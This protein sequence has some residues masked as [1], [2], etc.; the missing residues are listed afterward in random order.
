MQPV[1]LVFYLV[2]I[3]CPVDALL[4]KLPLSYDDCLQLQAEL[5]ALVAAEMKQAQRLEASLARA[6][7]CFWVGEV[8]KQACPKIFSGMRMLPTGLTG[9]HSP[10][11]P[12]T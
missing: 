12:V 5:K 6:Q 10:L 2:Q 4:L 9:T 1:R 3:C 8:L 7:V 11:W